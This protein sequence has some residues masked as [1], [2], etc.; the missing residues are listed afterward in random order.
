[1]VT[2]IHTADKGC[3]SYIGLAQEFDRVFNGK[4]QTNFAANPLFNNN[5]RAGKLQSNPC[6]NLYLLNKH[7]A[8]LSLC[9]DNVQ[10]RGG[11]G[12]RGE[13]GGGIGRELS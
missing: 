3:N 7:K 13:E 1:M 10:S 6:H 8:S 4:T 9:K 12:K 2:E 11:G 5:N